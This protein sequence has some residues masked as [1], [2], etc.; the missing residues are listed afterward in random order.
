MASPPWTLARRSKLVE[1]QDWFRGAEAFEASELTRQEFSQQRRLLLSTLHS[2][3]Y[4]RRRQRARKAEPVRL[5]RV[6]GAAAPQPSTTRLVVVL[7]NEARLRFAVAPDAGYGARLARRCK[8]PVG[9][10][11]LS[12]CMLLMPRLVAGTA[13]HRLLLR[14]RGARAIRRRWLGE[15]ARIELQPFLHLPVLLPQLSV[16]LLQ[17]SD[18]LIHGPDE[19]VMDRGLNQRE[20]NWS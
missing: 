20:Q 2:W 11:V 6:E 17:V 9:D 4:R 7:A 15:V 18:A 14:T 12:D 5:L 3:V 10:V 1:K 19:F 8:R 16:L 13:P